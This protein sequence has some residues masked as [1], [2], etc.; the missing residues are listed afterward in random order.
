MARNIY[1]ALS[2]TNLVTVDD[3][4]V[5]TGQK[6][7]AAATTDNSV[8]L[9]TIT[10]P[11]SHGI[12]LVVDAGV[13]YASIDDGTSAYNDGSNVNALGIKI[14]ANNPVFVPIADP[15][16]IVIGSTAASKVMTFICY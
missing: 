3:S 7:T 6:T 5:K 2:G 12:Y 4:L 16:K 11:L 13:F 1:K 10:G 14:S 9:T 15:S 8:H